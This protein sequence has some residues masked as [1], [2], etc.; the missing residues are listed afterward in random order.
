[1]AVDA[2][3]ATSAHAFPALPAVWRAFLL[4]RQPPMHVVGDRTADAARTAGFH[5]VRPG[6]GDAA[7]LARQLLQSLTP[8]SHLLYLAGDPRK[9]F[10]EQQLEAQGHAVETLELY[11]AA[12]LQEPPPA[13]IEALTGEPLAVLHFSRASAAS[14]AALAERAGKMK[15]AAAAAHIC[16]S[17]DVAGGLE[18]LA[19][20]DLSIASAPHE[21]ALL[22]ALAARFAQNPPQPLGEG[23]A[24]NALGYSQSGRESD[25]EGM[26]DT[27]SPEPGSPKRGG[28]RKPQTIDLK[29]AEVIETVPADAASE[30]VAQSPAEPSSEALTEPETRFEPEAATPEPPEAQAAEPLAARAEPILPAAAQRPGRASALAAG[31]L[32][33][34]AAAILVSLA[35][36]RLLAPDYEGRLT[37]LEQR[38][39]AVAPTVDLKPALERLGALEGRL[40]AAEEAVKPLAP[41]IEALSGLPDA[42]AALEARAGAV[43]GAP[44]ADPA[45]AKR[46]GAAEE[47]IAA[48]QSEIEAL[49]AAPPATLNP[50]V[51]AAARRAAVAALTSKFASGQ[52]FSAELAVIAGFG[53]DAPGLDLLKS[54]STGA[55]TLAALADQFRA[56]APTINDSIQ[57]KAEDPGFLQR[58]ADSAASL[59]EVT[60]V[61]GG[62]ADPRSLAGRVE[63]AI[64]SGSIDAALGELSAL[65]EPARV[66]AAPSIEALTKRAAL[67]KALAELAAAVTGGR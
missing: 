34:A 57:P 43:P 2:A 32:A 54:E 66:A 1:M 3:I 67:D 40:S 21:A 6:P 14:F 28:R 31:A 63:A 51:E 5:D 59:V 15:Q 20:R 48:L 36:S 44:I 8:R 23:D 41:R 25:G 37:A 52:D 38:P 11:R 46:L 16:L 58:L 27:S 42:V 49:K 62:A 39:A 22:E 61:D 18:P 60:P 50:A 47:R 7:G 12:P 19:P 29:P 13:L 10:I 64:R 30:P 26:S 17:Q 65:P 33:G 4:D 45:L 35:A 24:E 55:P 9:P 56:L 53:G